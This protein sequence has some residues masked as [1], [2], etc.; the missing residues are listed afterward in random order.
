VRAAVV[1]MATSGVILTSCWIFQS[2]SRYLVATPYY[3]SRLHNVV[4]KSSC[5]HV[6]DSKP[7]AQQ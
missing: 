7:A 1:S 2:S 6:V 5:I 4:T 3:I